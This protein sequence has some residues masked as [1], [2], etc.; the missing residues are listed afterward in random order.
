MIKRKISKDLIGKERG[1][2][3][4]AYVDIVCMEEYDK[5]TEI[6]QVGKALFWYE[7]EVEN[8]GHLQYLFNRGIEELELTIKALKFVYHNDF[9]P[10][11]EQAKKIYDNLDFS[12]VED[13][14]SYVEM[15]LDD[16][17]GYCDEQFY[18]I[19]P[20]LYS[21]QLSFLLDFQQEFIEI[22]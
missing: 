13:I 20:S 8:G 18:Q 2:I 15:A 11:L 9:I 14:E 12:K 7:N 4:N 10:L 22:I 5:L 21:L 19:T 1:L 3:W 17:F 16:H 6:Q